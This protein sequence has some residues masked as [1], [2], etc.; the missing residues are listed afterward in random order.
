M[1]RYDKLVA[2]NY[3]AK[4]LRTQHQKTDLPKVYTVEHVDSDGVFKVF[5]VGVYE[6]PLKFDPEGYPLLEQC[7]YSRLANTA[8]YWRNI[9]LIHHES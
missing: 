8:K 3:E 9:R 1:K 5:Q 7:N 6:K 2:Y 4:K